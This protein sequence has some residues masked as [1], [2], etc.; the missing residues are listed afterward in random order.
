VRSEDFKAV[1]ELAVSRIEA[2]CP[3][4]ADSGRPCWVCRMTAASV[5]DLEVADL[6][7]DSQTEAC[8]CYDDPTGLMHCPAHPRIGCNCIECRRGES[9]LRHD[10]WMGRFG[11]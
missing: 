4:F 1:I 11:P 9:R 10:P 6:G 5:R 2:G 8:R 7:P 3:M